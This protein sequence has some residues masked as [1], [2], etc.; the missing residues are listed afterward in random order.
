MDQMASLAASNAL[1]MAVTKPSS[2]TTC[3]RCLKT[4]P[5]QCA[6]SFDA[7]TLPSF[8]QNAV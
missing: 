5:R 4:W 6:R 1:G 2:S 3:S 8:L 7:T